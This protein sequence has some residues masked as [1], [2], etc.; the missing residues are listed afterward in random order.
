MRC[1]QRR[2]TGFGTQRTRTSGG[3]GGGVGRNMLIFFQTQMAQVYLI[4]KLHVSMTISLSS[5]AHTW[6]S[7]SQK[8]HGAE[9][10]GTEWGSSLPLQSSNIRR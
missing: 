8:F 7:L 3:K 4:A 10:N 1:A 9:H 5:E 6:E 2:R